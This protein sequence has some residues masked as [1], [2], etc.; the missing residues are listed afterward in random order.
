[1]APG[2]SKRMRVAAMVALL[3]S[4]LAF[5]GCLSSSDG[6]V[7]D[8]QNDPWATLRPVSEKIFDILPVEELWINANDGKGLHHAIYRPDTDEPVPVF[9][10]FSPYWGDTAELGGDGFA[11]YMINEYVPRG[12]AVVLSAIRGTGHSEGCFQIGG[13][14]EVAD[15]YDMVNYFANEPWSNGNVAAGGKSYDSTTQNGMIAK[16]PHPALKGIFHVSGITDMYRYNYVNGV[17]YASGPIF[18]TYYYLQGTDEYG[19]SFL[20]TPS[21]NVLEEEDATS[22]ARAI[23]DAACTE[24]PQM[25]ASGVGSGVTGL[26]DAYWQ[27]RDWNRYIGDSDWDGS[28]FFVHGLQDWNVKP[29]HILPW[30]DALPD[31]IRVK[32]WLH[33]DT[34][35]NGHL[36][37]M[38]DDWNKTMLAWL[39][40]ELK[41][42]DTGI[43]NQPNWD[44]QGTD[45]NWRQSNTWPPTAEVQTLQESNIIPP[46]NVAIGI[47]PN[48]VLRVEFDPSELGAGAANA[49]GYTRLSGSPRIHIAATATGPD[50]ILSAVLLVDGTWVGEAVLRAI[51]KNG[52]D[53]PEPV[54]PGMSATYTLEAYPLDLVL[55]PGQK[56]TVEFGA[57]PREA[58]ALPTNLAMVQYDA[59]LIDFEGT[60]TPADTR[61]NQP[62]PTTC[63]A[64]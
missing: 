25:Q 35:N 49:T 40:S 50:P 5:A 59:S 53:A 51:Y 46:G 56:L 39:D 55:A 33:Q 12:Y 3:M 15:L 2:A 26:K 19:L 27:E 38:R 42:A 24:L 23:E 60:F 64:C 22:L 7:D 61:S 10:N 52:L 41:G 4:S 29:D 14:R 11:Q 36:Y 31:Q 6:P 20:S 21:P 62:A 63:F 44:V 47:S 37:P 17:P 30:I 58:L 48:N 54:V 9:I 57:S 16:M 13:D 32:G 45:G 43:W 34:E 1:M 8:V 18:N 28:I